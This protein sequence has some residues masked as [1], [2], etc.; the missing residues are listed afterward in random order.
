MT[1]MSEIETNLAA[2]L[3][4]ITVANGYATGVRKVYFNKIP[5]GLELEPHEVPAIFVLVDRVQIQR[6][7]HCNENI[8]HFEIQLIGDESET[9]D[10]MF[11]FLTDVYKAVYA[12]SPTSQQLDQYRTIHESIYDCKSESGRFDL[13]MIEANRFGILDLQIYFRANY[14][15]L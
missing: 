12:N 15:N 8:L 3:N 5:M 1:T 2:R 7:V 14:I 4:T 11:N 13:N 9:D 6:K 10:Y